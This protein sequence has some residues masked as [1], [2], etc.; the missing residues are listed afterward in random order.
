MLSIT[1]QSYELNVAIGQYQS[2]AVRFSSDVMLTGKMTKFNPGI[3]TTTEP[4][5]EDTC[6]N[7]QYPAVAGTYP[8][9]NFGCKNHKAFLKVIDSQ[10]FEIEFRFFV[11]RNLGN[12]MP[13]VSYDYTTIFDASSFSSIIGLYVRI[14]RSEI[15]A[16]IPINVS[17]NGNEINFDDDGFFPAQNCD[18]IIKAPNGTANNFYLGIIRNDA[19]N[20]NLEITKGLIQS[21]VRVGNG[22]SNVFDIESDN[23]I[24]GWGFIQSGNE[25]FAKVT[26]NGEYLDTSATF[27]MY[28]IY[29]YDGKW[30]MSKSNLL[31]PNF[32]NEPIV[33]VV[34]YSI[35]DSFGNNTNAGKISG[36]SNDIELD[37]QITID[38]DDY[39]SKLTAL[40]FTGTF[41]TVFEKSSVFISK[42][43]NSY[44]G[45]AIMHT[46]A[47]NVFTVSGFKNKENAINVIFKLTMNLPGYKD[48]IFIPVELEYNALT[49]NLNVAV[50]EGESKVDRLCDGGEYK[51]NDNFDDC[52][53]LQSINGSD[54][55]ENTIIDESGNIDES[56]IALNT[57]PCFKVICDN[58]IQ[59]GGN[60]DPDGSEGE[61]DDVCDKIGIKVTIETYYSEESNTFSG[62]TA[63]IELLSGNVE[64]S[65]I[66]WSYN[67][68][69]NGG[70]ISTGQL[71]NGKIIIQT[72]TYEL[73]NPSFPAYANSINI[74]N[75][76]IE[77]SDG[78][79]Y[80]KSLNIDLVSQQ[81]YGTGSTTTEENYEISAY[82][83]TSVPDP[84]CENIVSI[85]YECDFENDTVTINLT[86]SY[87]STIANESYLFSFDGGKTWVEGTEE[88]SGENVILVK[89]S[90]SFVEKCNPVLLQEIIDCSPLGIRSVCN[91]ERTIELSVS[92]GTLMIEVTT[93][94]ESN[95]LTDTLYVSIDGGLNYSESNIEDYVPIDISGSEKIIVYTE[96]YFDDDCDKLIS[97]ETLDLTSETG[98]EECEGYVGYELA[99]EYNQTTGK[100]EVTKTGDQEPL[101]INELL[102]TLNGGNPFDENKSGIEYV[103]PVSG[104]GTFIARWKIK[105]INCSET[106]IDAIAFGTK[107]TKVICV[108]NKSTGNEFIVTDID[109]LKIT[110]PSDDLEV[111]VNTTVQ[112]YVSG[113][114]LASGQYTITALGKLKFFIA[115]SNATIKITQY[116]YL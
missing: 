83:C 93:N 108:L 39:N 57:K 88:V 100:F 25:T 84:V 80:S 92:N 104:E 51:I 74:Q 98:N 113:D 69:G 45:T 62:Q 115:L 38:K 17:G 75:I 78:C 15:V 99:A 24:Q 6:F 96:T 41:D 11:S 64:N 79:K 4:Y 102:W 3:Y 46:V 44:S 12:W 97:T 50:Y 67:T 26:L 42:S 36:L 19:I 86:K 13:N 59:G 68:N 40:G 82:D 7:I 73:S 18:I 89:Y 116:P 35:T 16:T 112:T 76:S 66:Q 1:S 81:I 65:E 94:F 28:A 20:S 5:P 10:N 52:V 33:P 95:V 2:I 34:E 105:N 14:A 47:S 37:I 54:Y 101:L 60:E 22:I 63:T 111:L 56:L 103:D 70:G 61:C 53:I 72:D 49:K 29:F 8:F 106:I 90:C 91:N 30:K 27:T 77:L 43:K 109:L 114:P 9:N 48:Y 21:Y 32:V 55:S 85:D 23:F 58:T 71:I 107:K 110:D 31:K 87:T